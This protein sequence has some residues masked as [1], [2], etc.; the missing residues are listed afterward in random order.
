MAKYKKIME[1]NSLQEC[2]TWL[3]DTSI[4]VHNIQI[5]PVF[6]STLLT[7]GYVAVTTQDDEN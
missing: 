2:N 4:P 7:I 1:F 6:I 5:I 3:K